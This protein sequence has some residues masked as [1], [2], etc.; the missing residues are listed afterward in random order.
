ME[1]TSP[2]IEVPVLQLKESDWK[3]ENMTSKSIV[4]FVKCRI[5]R[6]C[7]KGE[8]QTS[9]RWE[10]SKLWWEIQNWYDLSELKTVKNYIGNQSLTRYLLFWTHPHVTEQYGTFA[11]KEDRKLWE[12]IQTKQQ[13]KHPLYESLKNSRWSTLEIAPKMS[14]NFARNLDE[15]WKKKILDYDTWEKEIEQY[16]IQTIQPII[17]QSPHWKKTTLEAYSKNIHQTIQ[18]VVD[19]SG[20]FPGM[21]STL[22]NKM[23][24]DEKHAALTVKVFKNITSH[25]LIALS[26]TEIMDR[27]DPAF[28]LK[29]FDF[30]LQNAGIEYIAYI[31]A[32]HDAFVS[33]GPYQH[34][35]FSV[36]GKLTAGKE[37]GAH[38]ADKLF[39]NGRI[40]Q[41]SNEEKVTIE[42]L[43]PQEQHAAAYLLAL[44]NI[45]N[46]I[47]QLDVVS[48]ESQH[49]KSA[50]NKQ[51]RQMEE[52][53]LS[54]LL[55]KCMK[56]HRTLCMN[57]LV[58]YIAASHNNPKAAVQGFKD[59]LVSY[60][61]HGSQT[62]DKLGKYIE[63]A[64]A[65]QNAEKQR[66]NMSGMEKSDILI[67][68]K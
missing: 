66:K 39:T 55:G 30:L 14:I 18:H 13:W 29:L 54:A 53:D 50:R 8:I 32:L 31:P 40:L 64:T 21:Q 61:H 36:W 28:N 15:L 5:F 7:E 46:L 34:T 52:I 37:A 24:F 65:K 22:Q 19:T 51:K 33:M 57:V 56:Q 63:K 11:S 59:W 49:K 68:S 25:D 45:S 4:D 62:E 44:K 20:G 27:L 41:R 9:T 48:V 3:R 47:R 1:Y 42:S 43:N 16:Y 60:R 17:A 2:P 10:L 38:Q 58:Q 67:A 6:I 35:K 12:I 26:M 23:W